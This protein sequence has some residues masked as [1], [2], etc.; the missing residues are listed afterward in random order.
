MRSALDGTECPMLRLHVLGGLSV[1]FELPRLG[2]LTEIR[3]R[4]TLIRPPWRLG[5]HH[6][7][8]GTMSADTVLCQAISPTIA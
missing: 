6:K 1:L 3:H 5:D 7:L 2:V 4:S 8:Y